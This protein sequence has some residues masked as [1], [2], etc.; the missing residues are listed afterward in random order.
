MSDPQYVYSSDGRRGVI[1]QSEDPATDDRR[2]LRVRFGDGPDLTV[3][4]ELLELRPDGAFALNAGHEQ[5][6]PAPNAGPRHELEQLPADRRSV[7]AEAV[8]GDTERLVVPVVAE[9]LLVGKR[10]VETGVVRVRKL[11]REHEETVEQPLLRE[12][13]QIERVPIGRVVDTTPAPRNEGE[14][15]VIPVFEEVLVVEKRVMLKEEVRVTWRRTEEREPQQV[16]LRSEE[17]VVERDRPGAG[18]G[19]NGGVGP[20]DPPVR[21]E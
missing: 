20:E 5:L 12:E 14:T 6:Q 1:V 15:L 16:L 19:A 8:V 21:A 9:E 2:F 11:V 3:P 18:D 4:A 13:V 10:L 7:A 17:L